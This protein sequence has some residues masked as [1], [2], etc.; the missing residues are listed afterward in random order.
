[1]RPERI[2]LAFTAGV[3]LLLVQSAMIGQQRQ[4]AGD[5]FDL[6][7]E[8][9]ADHYLLYKPVDSK[10]LDAK[11]EAK[12]AELVMTPYHFFGYE[13][14]GFGLRAG[15][16]QPLGLQEMLAAAAGYMPGGKHKVGADWKRNVDFAHMVDV[17]ALPLTCEMMVARAEDYDKQRCAVI[18]GLWQMRAEGAIAAPADGTPRATWLAFTLNTTCWFDSARRQARGLRFM[19]N[20]ELK[21]ADG[22]LSRYGWSG[23]WRLAEQIDGGDRPAL[24]GRIANA[25]AK[26]VDAL[27]AIQKDGLWP[28]YQHRRGGT[29]L[30][31]TALLASDVS[32]SDPRIVK[33]FEAMKAEPVETTYAASISI[34]AIEAKYVDA[35]ERKH[36][37][38]GAEELPPLKRNLSAEDRAEVQRLVEW[39]VDNRNKDNPLWTYSK[40]RN[41]GWCFSTT[42]YVM[43]GFSAAA[44][45]GI[46]LPALVPKSVSSYL[47]KYQQQNGP[48]LKRVVA[49]KE[50]AKGVASFARAQKQ[51]DSR[52]WEYMTWGMWDE[53]TWTGTPYGSMTCAGLITQMICVDWGMGLKDAEATAEFGSKAEQGKWNLLM[54]N[55][56]EGGLTWLEYFYSVTRNPWRS[57]FHEYYY[58]LYSLERVAMFSGMRY[59]G[60]HNWY[61]EGSCPL[62]ALQADDGKWGEGV[63]ETSF[64]LLFLKKGTVPLRSRVVTGEGG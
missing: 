22:T 43:M 34:L 47:L 24:N 1:M 45:C 5:R 13:M 30:A 4:V 39:L 27:F 6:S 36:Y 12:P 19:L 54:Q 23:E 57:Q 8:V 48:K 26:G 55:S 46:K 28:F 32:P 7:W 42:H 16:V 9:P 25:I 18:T 41:S 11:G 61:Y 14:D 58:Y 2:G 63:V 29:A 31:L 56:L 62:L 53:K 59:I 17:P 44:R 20:A 15:N 35:E 10:L 50:N 49:A 64:A 60:E 51:T 21:A 38:A 40:E 37:V 3:A 52:G 33:A